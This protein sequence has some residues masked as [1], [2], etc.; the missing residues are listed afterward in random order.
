MALWVH[1]FCLLNDW[2]SLTAYVC[3]EL[4]WIKH[5]LIASVAWTCML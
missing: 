4:F 2:G 1:P 5:E 3:V